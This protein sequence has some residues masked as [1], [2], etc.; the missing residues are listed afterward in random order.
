MGYEKRKCLEVKRLILLYDMTECGGMIGST[1]NL[2]GLRNE[3]NLLN[4]I[5]LLQPI[6]LSNL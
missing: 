2:S 4:V 5:N 3:F 1:N 6:K